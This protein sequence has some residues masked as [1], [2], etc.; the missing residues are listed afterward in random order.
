MKYLTQ[1]EEM[2]IKRGGQR[3]YTKSKSIWLT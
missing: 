1:I 3:G 2:L